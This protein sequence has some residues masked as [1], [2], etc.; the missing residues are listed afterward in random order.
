M[1][2]NYV[3]IDNTQLFFWYFRNKTQVLPF[4]TSLRI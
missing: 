1:N 4:N 2:N 3:V